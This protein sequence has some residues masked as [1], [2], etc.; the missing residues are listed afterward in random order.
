MI[1]QAIRRIMALKKGINNVK[2][3]KDFSGLN[4]LDVA[5]GS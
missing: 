3:I 4:V 5:L 2:K 1:L